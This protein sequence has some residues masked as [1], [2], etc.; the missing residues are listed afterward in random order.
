MTSA[1]YEP[2]EDDDATQR[3]TTEQRSEPDPAA[4]EDVAPGEPEGA[5]STQGLDAEIVDAE[6]VD[7]EV[8]DAEVSA[9]DGIDQSVFDIADL[10]G[11][12][13]L[14]GDDFARIAAERDEYL[15][16]LQ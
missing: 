12:E 3:A 1:H 4:T 13:E 11:L 9:S 2:S 16:A 7:A 6:I 5:E 8:L 15:G 10:T 14:L